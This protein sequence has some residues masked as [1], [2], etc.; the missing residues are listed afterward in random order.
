MASYIHAV[1][2]GKRCAP[3]VFAVFETIASYQDNLVVYCWLDLISLII[4][5]GGCLIEVVLLRVCISMYCN[6]SRWGD[7]ASYY[8]MQSIADSLSS[9][10][11]LIMCYVLY[12]CD[13]ISWA[14]LSS[15]IW[16]DLGRRYKIRVV[17]H[18]IC[19]CIINY[20]QSAC[21]LSNAR[22]HKVCSRINENSQL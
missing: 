10:T 13:L 7:G 8:I 21:R 6:R 22:N 1:L 19:F 5:W 9:A 16:H 12:M 15:C 4:E 2:R 11:L 18:S 14:A 17:R 3:A 20:A